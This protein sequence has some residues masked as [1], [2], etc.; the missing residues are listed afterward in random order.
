M[1]WRTFGE[2]WVLISQGQM[3]LEVG[4]QN[5]IQEFSEVHS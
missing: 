3:I 4:G 2:I 5:G 1:A